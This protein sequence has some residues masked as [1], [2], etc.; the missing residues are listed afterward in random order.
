MYRTTFL[1]LSASWRKLPVH[2]QAALPRG[3]RA[4]DTHWIRDCVDPRVGLYCVKKRNFLTLVGIEIRP[5]QPVASRYVIP[6][7]YIMLYLMMFI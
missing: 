5:L 7:Y 1:Y 4:A 6:A 2:A 3:E